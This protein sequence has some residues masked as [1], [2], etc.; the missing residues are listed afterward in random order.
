M[1]MIMIMIVAHR[2]SPTFTRCL[3]ANNVVACGYYVFYGSSSDLI[4]T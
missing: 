1:I 3:F 4:P 2:Y